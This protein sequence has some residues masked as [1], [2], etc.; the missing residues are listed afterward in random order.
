MNKIET[1][2]A[3]SILEKSRDQLIKELAAAGDAGSVGRA[4]NY[5]PILMN[6]TGSIKALSEM[7]PKQTDFVATKAAK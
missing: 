4:Q 6:I 1:Q 7:L 3:I 5:A 2:K